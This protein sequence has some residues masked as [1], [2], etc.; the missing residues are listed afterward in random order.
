M[1][2]IMPATQTT[3]DSVSSP[4]APALTLMQP[5]AAAPQLDQIMQTGLGF[6]ASKTL[7]S[8]VELGVFTELAR[9]PLDA[10][11]LRGR[12]GLHTRSAR[13]FFDALV[14]MKFL[15][16]HA[17]QYSNTAET[18]FYLDRRKRRRKFL[19]TTFLRALG[20]G[21][22]EEIIK[23]ATKAM[24]GLRPKNLLVL[25]IQELARTL[26]ISE[27]RGVGNRVQ[28]FRARMNNPLVPARKIRFDF[29]AL[30]TEVGGELLEDGWHGLPLTTPRR[31]SDQI[32][33]NKRSM[34]AKRYLLLDDLSR[35][36][37]EH[38]KV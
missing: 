38:M 29:D 12:V 35:Q 22:D 31:S 37:R 10:E 24:H 1:I 36:I 13:D 5:P 27:L 2:A 23:L 17:G 7:L 8:A 3:Q 4:L 26:G 25:L 28:V 19:A 14:A 15:Q 34:Y 6:W 9:G 30:W 16:R 32:K 11:T 20:Y 33:P 18:D 21:T